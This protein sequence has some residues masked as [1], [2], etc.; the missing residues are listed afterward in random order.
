MPFLSVRIRKQDEDK[1]LEFQIMSLEQIVGSHLKF[2]VPIKERL[3][4][5][6]RRVSDKYQCC[7]TLM[8]FSPSQTD[9]S[10]APWTLII[11][12][13]GERKTLGLLLI[14]NRL[15]GVSPLSIG[16]KMQKTA[17]KKGREPMVKYLRQ[18]VL[19][20]VEDPDQWVKITSY[21]AK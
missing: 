6:V 5:M 8:V 17:Q 14:G 19:S 7:N 4:E 12:E 15:F 18:L 3:Q 20:I 2:E 16:L 10:R 21:T 13:K 11:G 1:P 9:I